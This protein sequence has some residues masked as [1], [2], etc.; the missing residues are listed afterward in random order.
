LKRK[1]IIIIGI[2]TIV[3]LIVSIFIGIYVGRD[4][5]NGNE[6]IYGTKNS[7]SPSPTEGVADTFTTENGKKYKIILADD[8][9][10]LYF[11]DELINKT[12][13]SADVLPRADIK[14]LSTGIEYNSLEEAL[15]DWESLCN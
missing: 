14:A 3:L 1:S 13:V 8:N 9:L 12:Q 4:N 2:I 5:K 11:E 6:P 7:H 15:V 10:M